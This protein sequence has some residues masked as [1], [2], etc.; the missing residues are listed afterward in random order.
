M[1]KSLKNSPYSG[2][3][4]E[5]TGRRIPLHAMLGGCGYNIETTRDYH[6]HGLQRG[7]LEFAI[8]QY[9]VSGQGRLECDGKSYDLNPGDAMMIHIPQ[10]NCYFLPE[11]SDKWEFLYLNVHGSEIMRIWREL[12]KRVGPVAH[13]DEK[14]PTLE[15]A[16]EIYQHGIAKN[17]KSS[18]FASSLAYQFMMTL[19]EE[20]LS[21]GK[22]V[23]K[24]PDFIGK[25][26]TYAMNHLHESLGVDDLANIAEYSRFHF[27]RIF[28]EWY[29][30]GPSTFLHDMRMKRAVRL[31]QT[32]RITI[33]EIA[34]R[35]GFT[36]T[37]YFC[38]V[39]RKEFEISPERFRNQK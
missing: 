21:G 3:P 2:F 35:C 22:H 34:D 25:V 12:G 19:V 1:L 14:S 5:F 23:E 16:C 39:F 20:L 29:G 33:K 31:L 36:D 11:D 6:W 37:S 9:T 15:L 7:H 8:W 17:I 24:T 4:I 38:K 32:E 27:S 26:T 18:H 30:A 10:E 28:K 13:F